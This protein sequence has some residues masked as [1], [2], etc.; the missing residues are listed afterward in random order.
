MP[1]PETLL[2]SAWN[3]SWEVRA[4]VSRAWCIRRGK[5][6]GSLRFP[7][8]KTGAAR[9]RTWGTQRP[10]L[11]HSRAPGHHQGDL[12]PWQQTLGSPV[13]RHGGGQ[14]HCLACQGPSRHSPR[15]SLGHTPWA[16]PRGSGLVWPPPSAQSSKPHYPPTSEQTSLM[17]SR[18]QRASWQCNTF[19]GLF[20][21]GRQIV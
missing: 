9:V 8:G 15:G 20:S 3:G 10:G 17:I 7:V 21:D 19:S 11:A 2:V 6:P 16:R 18:K 14:V 4:G 12:P 5:V 1:H 13:S